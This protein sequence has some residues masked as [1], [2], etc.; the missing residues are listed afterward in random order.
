M[1]IY[2]CRFYV[3]NAQKMFESHDEKAQHKCMFDIER[4]ETD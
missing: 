4:E 1:L 2:L 3:K